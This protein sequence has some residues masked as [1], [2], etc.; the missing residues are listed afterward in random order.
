MSLRSRLGNDFSK[1]GQFLLYT[2]R[3]QFTVC[4]C[5][6][7]CVCVHVCVRACVC[8]RMC[9]RVQLESE[10]VSKYSMSVDS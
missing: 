3:L 10:K 9:V 5:V 6:C 8:A 1:G 4:V 7:V 2:H